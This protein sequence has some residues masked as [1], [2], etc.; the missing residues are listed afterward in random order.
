MHSGTPSGSK[1]TQVI[2]DAYLTMGGTSTLLE[3]PSIVQKKLEPYL[4]TTDYVEKD[5][6]A[7]TW[8]HTHTLQEKTTH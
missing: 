4:G 5:T 8:I 6:L 2:S 3:C 7:Y 1:S